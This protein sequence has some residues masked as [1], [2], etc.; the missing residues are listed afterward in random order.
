M[1]NFFNKTKFN[2]K[3]FCYHTKN[4]VEYGLIETCLKTLNDINYTYELIDSRAFILVSTN[5]NLKSFILSFEKTGQEIIFFEYN[6]NI[7]KK[8]GLNINNEI[9]KK[10]EL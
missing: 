5:S 4:I 3:I 6:N 7:R 2:K 1:F 10:L 9:K 8:Y